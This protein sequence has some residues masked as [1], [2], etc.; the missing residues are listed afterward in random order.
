[1]RAARRDSVVGRNELAA[2]KAKLHAHAVS[3]K[4]AYAVALRARAEDRRARAIVDALPI[5]D[6]EAPP[7]DLLS[8]SCRT[9]SLQG[10]ERALQHS[11]DMLDVAA[12]SCA[13]LDQSRVKSTLDAFAAELARESSDGAARAAALHANDERLERRGV[14]RCV[15][16]HTLTQNTLQ[17]QI[18][19]RNRAV[20]ALA[21]LLAAPRD[22]V[23][24]VV[25]GAA[26]SSEHWAL[27]DL[28]FAIQAL[29]ST[30]DA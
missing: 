26:E 22:P 16:M 19:I 15:D 3:L 30:M 9:A 29:R 4:D 21:A 18:A 7:I 17:R 6:D 11:Q 5:E 28:D 12:R 14:E 27:G 13:R 25:P 20:A 1:M 23:S 2:G 24:E 10:A 8:T